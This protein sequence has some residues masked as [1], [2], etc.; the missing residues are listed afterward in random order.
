MSAAA[1]RNYNAIISLP[2]S[3]SVLTHHLAGDE[4][5]R[6]EEPGGGRLHGVGRSGQR[7]RLREEAES[8]CGGSARLCSVRVGSGRLSA[9]RSASG[10][11]P[12]NPD[13]GGSARL[14]TDR[15]GSDSAQFGWRAALDAFWRT[16]TRAAATVARRRGGGGGAR[17]PL[18]LMEI[19][20]SPLIFLWHVCMRARV[21]VRANERGRE[22]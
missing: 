7:E 22:I 15:N 4:E 8:R 16:R 19:S 20:V 1:A 9:Q 13:L 21:R 11:S 6:D 17:R 2:P 12:P 18:H 10:S 3:L 5:L 14:G